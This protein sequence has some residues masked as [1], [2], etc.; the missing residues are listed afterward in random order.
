MGMS[1]IAVGVDA[2][3]NSE[4]ALEWAMREGVFRGEPVTAI[5]VH[6]VATNQW[7]GNPIIMGGDQAEEEEIRRALEEKVAKVAGRI[8]G[9]PVEVGVQVVSGV[10]ARVLIEAS[11]H[12]DLLV[13]SSRG[14]GGFARMLMGSV[15]I[16]VVQHAACPV[17]VVR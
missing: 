2:S 8:G 3:E 14:G 13:V 17:T 6:E 15:S 1:G 4:R 10:A 9:A 11:E 5:A 16:Q 12:A 7:T